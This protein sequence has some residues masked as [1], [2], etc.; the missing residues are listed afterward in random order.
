MAGPMLVGLVSVMSISVVDT[1][2]VGQLGTLPLAA[3]SYSFPVIFF[4]GGITMGLSAATSSVVS[5]AVGGDDELEANELTSHAFLLA[6]LLVTTT[7]AVGFPFITGV[8]ELLGTT[9]EAMP[10]VMDY[11]TVWLFGMFF[12]VG[13]VIGSSALRARGDA[14]TP[15]L[16]MVGVTVLNFILDPILIFGLGPMPKL[17]VVGA[18]LASAIARAIATGITL[19]ILIRRDH[20]ITPFVP[21]FWR[22]RESWGHLSRIAAPAGATNVI[23]PV[24]T[25]ILTRLVSEYGE[26]AVAAYGAGSRIQSFAMLVPMALGA[27]LSPIAGQNWGAKLV[28][29]V[30]GV[31]NLSLAISVAWGVLGWI[32]FFFGS[33]FV[34]A[35]FV[36]GDKAAG[37]LS[38][39]LWIVPFGQAFQ[40][41]FIC[42]NSALNAIDYPYH[43]GALSITRTLLL[44][45]P[46]AWLGAYWM[47]L[48]G[49]FISIP[50]ANV[51]VGLAAVW[52]TRSVIQSES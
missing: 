27:G 3:M 26:P 37:Y 16:I 21:R 48:T 45:A 11:M 38:L 51:L 32:F 14:K 19:W 28:G 17:G 33:D 52:L 30:K 5:R 50:V 7:I 41:L 20:L 25:A 43:A 22:V 13:P 6:L 9:P 36:E 44:T 46:L 29:R 4:V 39:F 24:T 8:F 12:F 34:A 47:E 31:L 49:I 18:A 10:L 40:G 15:M 35:F 1:Y 2:F 23:V 42:C